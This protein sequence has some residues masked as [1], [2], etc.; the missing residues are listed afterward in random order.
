[1]TKKAAAIL[2]QKQI[3]M[4]LQSTIIPDENFHN[5][6][7]VDEELANAI[8][9]GEGAQIVTLKEFNFVIKRTSTWRTLESM[10]TL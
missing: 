9:D 4:K 1:M 2:K 3:L 6:W 7:V 10:E 8:K 5:R